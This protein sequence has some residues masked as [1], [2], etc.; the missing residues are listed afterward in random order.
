MY[1][2]YN[3]LLTLY[4]DRQILVSNHATRLTHAQHIITMFTP[5]ISAA[6]ANTLA[7]TSAPTFPAAA[8]IPFRVDRHS[9]EY[10][11][12]GNMKVVVFGP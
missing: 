4:R 11:T 5:H 6:G 2:L 1:I 10:V 3:S 9:S 12:E 8:L 7:P